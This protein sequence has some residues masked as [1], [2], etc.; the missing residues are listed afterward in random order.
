ML[1]FALRQERTKSTAGTSRPTSTAPAVPPSRAIALQDVNRDSDKD[2]SGSSEGGDDLAERSGKAN[3]A[4]SAAKTMPDTTAWKNLA[5]PP[6]DPKA[7]ARSREYLKQCLQEIGYLTSPGVLNP[8]PSRAPVSVDETSSNPDTS[9]RPRKTLSE[10]PVPSTFP[11][12]PSKAPPAS[13]STARTL[14]N[15]AEEHAAPAPAPAP[16]PSFD[17]APPPSSPAPKTVALPEGEPQDKD[18]GPRQVITAIY[19]PESKAAW[20]EEL[21][22][23]NEA[24]SN[25]QWPPRRTNDEEQ[26]ASVALVEEEAK[27]DT[28]AGSD[29]WVTRRTLKSHLDVVRAVAFGS[30]ADL[31]FATGGDDCTVKVWQLDAREV[32]SSK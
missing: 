13:T 9:E 8:L 30:G 4:V 15:G 12:P 19:R 1:E 25:V 21:R 22:A 31:V 20:R 11:P 7:R 6:R 10:Q 23:A 26:L 16:T 28:D 24:V 14:L 5:A 17:A 18:D 3:G 29:V 32:L 2:G 27:E